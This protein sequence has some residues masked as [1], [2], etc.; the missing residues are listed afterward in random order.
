ML[1]RKA[2]NH[3]LPHLTPWGR[4]T[5]ICVGKLT[6]IGSDNGLSPGWRLAIICTKYC[7]IVNLTLRNKLQWN[8]NR[9]WN[10]FIQENVFENIVCEMASIMCRPQ[11]VNIL[12]PSLQESDLPKV[13]WH[14]LSSPSP[15]APICQTWS[16]WSIEVNEYLAISYA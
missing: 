2:H 4:V 12:T 5:H 13:V 14:L 7:N 3:L 1:Q 10:I 16:V 6:I 15:L 8:F 11:C 9:N